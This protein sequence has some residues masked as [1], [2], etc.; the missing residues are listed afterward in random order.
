MILLFLNQMFYTNTTL[1]TALSQI[2]IGANNSNTNT[3]LD[4]G[5]VQEKIGYGS[6][7]Y[8]LVQLFWYQYWLS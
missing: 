4:T 3:I 8:F 1:D 7:I 2:G 6:G 5:L